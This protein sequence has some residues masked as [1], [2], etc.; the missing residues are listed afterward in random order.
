MKLL[1]KDGFAILRDVFSED[2][3]SPLREEADRIAISAGSA[4]VR[5]IRAKS[6]LFDSLALTLKTK[7]FLTPEMIPVRS[8]LFDK[9]DSE[10]WPVPWHQDLTI[11]VRNHIEADGYGP[12]SVKERIPHVQP[13]ESLLT[14]MVTVRIHLDPTPAE[15][16]ALKVIPGSHLSGRLKPDQIRLHT[17]SLAVTCSCNPGDVLLMSPLILHASSRAENPRRRRVLHFEFAPAD[18][19]PHGLEWHEA[20]N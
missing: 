8:I 7:D 4:C 12:W 6:S 5:D 17:E 11:A 15:N 13:P 3:L 16:G 18:A 20:R 1:E 9:T 10:N 2:E 19:L 14:K